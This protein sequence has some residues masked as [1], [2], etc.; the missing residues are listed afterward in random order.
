VD[1]LYEF[2]GDHV[3]RKSYVSVRGH[4]KSV[5]KFK[6]YRGSDGYN[7]V[8]PEY[9]G[10]WSGLGGDT[11]YIMPDSSGYVSPIDR[12]Y[13]EGRKAHREHLARHDVYEAGDM[14]LGEFAG[15]ERAPM[16]DIKY[17]IR[18]AMSELGA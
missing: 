2:P 11:P 3:G 7:Y 5:P 16:P 9:G 13:Y 14:K 10:D 12:Q 1:E 17:D 6:T 15:R 8:R 4:S 18:R